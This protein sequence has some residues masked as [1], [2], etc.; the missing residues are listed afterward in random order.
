MSGKFILTYKMCMGENDS[1]A[2]QNDFWWIILLLQYS[3]HATQ[4]LVWLFVQ[5][6][7]KN[8]LN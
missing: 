5:I 3:F 8:Y 7:P 6:L 2:L 4:Y 1:K